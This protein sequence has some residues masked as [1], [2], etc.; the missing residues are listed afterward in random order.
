[1]S[2]YVPV[3]IQRG[4]NSTI[5]SVVNNG[6]RLNTQGVKTMRYL[7]TMIRV[8]NLDR[9]TSFYQ[10][11]LGFREIRRA[12]YPDDKFTLVFLQAQGETDDVFGPMLE[13]TYNYG[14]ESYQVGDGYGHIALKVD[15]MTELQET[16]EQ[17]GLA[18]SWGP[19]VTP[20]GRKKMAFLT[21]P[22]GYKIELIE[23]SSE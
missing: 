18:F 1:M 19:G 14:V 2:S 3:G 16:I 6:N 9:S 10:D 4:G 13:L 21:D 12:D 5:N 15:S 20:D 8:G 17:N 23:Y 11:I 7:H 22:D